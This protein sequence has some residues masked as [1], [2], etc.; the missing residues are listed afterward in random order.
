MFFKQFF[1]ACLAHASYMIGSE[2]EA[3]V[4][5]PQRDVDQY[6]ETAEKEGLKIKYIIE[7]HVHADFVGGHRELAEKTGAEIVF[8]KRAEAS[9]AHRAV[10]DG[11]SIEFGKVKLDILATPG[12][13]PESIC[14]LVTDKEQSDKPAMVLTGDTLFIGDVGRPDLVSAKGFSSEE[15][16]GLLYDSLRQKLL[17]LDD[18]VLVYPAHGAG[19]LCGKNMSAE[20][21]ST[22]GQQRQFNYA[23]KEMSKDDFIAMMCTD[24]PEVPAY[25]PTAVAKNREGAQSLDR[26]SQPKPMNPQEVHEAMSRGHLVVDTRTN[27]LYGG[28]HVPGSINIGLGGQFASWAGALIPI[29]TPLILVVEEKEQIDEAITRLARA[30][31][32]SVVGYLEGGIYAWIKSGHDTGETPQI[33]IDQLKEKMAEV[34]DLQVIDVRRKGE[35]E[36]G[37]V[38]GAINIPLADLKRNLD[39]VDKRRP[40]AIICASG[41]RSSIS[42]HILKSGGVAYLY[43]TVGGTNAWRTA[44]YEVVVEENAPSCSKA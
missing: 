23:L 3:C 44:G 40:T 21:F 16:A 43:N 7:T 6:L 5:D 1:L 34:K 33:T 4:V 20:R 19:S 11:D 13:T 28:G 39:K 27:T 25:F 42:T 22:I 37:H 8:S 12:H 17:K 29:G 31:H 26:L 41:Y 2:G 30:G 14:V 24:L 36:A 32:E 9:F 15:M 10:D 38:P 35:Y 18:Q